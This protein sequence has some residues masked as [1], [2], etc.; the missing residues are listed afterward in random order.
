MAIESPQR[1]TLNSIR[2]TVEPS[3]PLSSA[4]PSPQPKRSAT[5]NLN[6][7]LPDTET[8]S[9]MSN[10]GLDGTSDAPP[11]KKRTKLTAEE[12]AER[13]KEKAERE[14]EKA[15]K[16]KERE[17]KRKEKEEKEKEKAKIK[18]EKEEQKKLKDEEKA[19]K[20]A[21][22]VAEKAKRD[23]EK[24][25]KE[26]EK[27]KKE[28]EKAKKE[29]EKAKKD[30]AQLRMD[31]F[32]SRKGPA[33]ASASSASVQTTPSKKD[34][35]PIKPSIAIQPPL[36]VQAAPLVV[37]MV[38]IGTAPEI[39]MTDKPE[40]P[41]KSD[42]T[43]YFHPFFA[44]AGVTV[45][46]PHSFQK[47]EAA[48]RY[49]C[50]EMDK[51]V[52]RRHLDSEDAMD[53]DI[54]KFEIPRPLPRSYFD[55]AF[56]LPPAK[57]HRRGNL[58]KISTKDILTGLN[59]SPGPV[60]DFSGDKKLQ[61]SDYVAYLKKLPRKYLKY[62]EDVRPGYYGTFT[63]IPKT[64]GLRKG[65]NPFQKSLPGIDYDYDSEAEWVQEPDDDGEEL[66]SEDDEDPMD[67][68]SADE[69]EDFLDDETEEVARKRNTVLGPLVPASSGLMWEDECPKTEEIEKYRLGVLIVGHTAPIDPFSGNYWVQEKKRP[70]PGRPAI[71]PQ[72]QPNHQYQNQSSRYLPIGPIP[73]Q[74][75]PSYAGPYP[76]YSR[77]YGS[78]HVVHNQRH[79]SLPRMDSA[80]RAS[81]HK[82]PY[83]PNVGPSIVHNQRYGGSHHYLNAP[84]PGIG[85]SQTNQAPMQAPMQASL[86]MQTSRSTANPPSPDYS[87][88]MEKLPP[89]LP[90]DQFPL[91]S[92][93]VY[94]DPHCKSLPR[95]RSRHFSVIPDVPYGKVCDGG[96]LTLKEL[97][98]LGSSSQNRISDRPTVALPPTS[99]AINLTVAGPSGTQNRT[100][101][102]QPKSKAGASSGS[103][104]LE[105]LRSKFPYDC[106]PTAIYQNRGGVEIP[107]IGLIKDTN[108]RETLGGGNG[109]NL[110][111]LD[112][113]AN[114]TFAQQI[115]MSPADHFKFFGILQG[116]SCCGFNTYDEF[117]NCVDF[118]VGTD[119]TK[120]G[121][122]EG[123]KK[124][125]PRITKPLLKVFMDTFCSRENVGGTKKWTCEFSQDENGFWTR[126]SA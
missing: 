7:S 99:G 103:Q 83:E 19:K 18:A 66:M 76:P 80:G 120:V 111:T 98:A 46:P 13:E 28:E 108:L 110:P 77:P 4:P 37:P 91:D 41:E 112:T 109:A 88:F 107:Y 106:S 62:A 9:K 15:A 72:Q 94:A 11:P 101:D 68:G 89:Y 122:L 31:S 104:G 102:A 26:E 78:H 1:D 116:I 124:E 42:F 6:D 117:K 81:T 44:R 87:Y 125:F 90:T 43:K 30:R 14:K 114:P 2:H 100:S 58:P 20:E 126:K 64:S 12:K 71:K 49:A 105:A 33:S 65:R 50:Q 92:F 32:F 97:Y 40:K 53:V 8:T 52:L 51:Y 86:P 70:A 35:S 118:I 34:A 39:E 5:P 113:L 24:A 95:P 82:K 96:P 59:S 48:S 121:M 60:P 47:D 3:S 56:A 55:E 57:R 16:E 54:A 17:E 63:R 38:K 29:E 123:L 45:A 36:A 93:P 85:S 79:A 23:E 25:K 119:L 73:R 74:R 75:A 10:L 21:E 67:V 69:M 61:N 115:G 22:K 84:Y 27:A